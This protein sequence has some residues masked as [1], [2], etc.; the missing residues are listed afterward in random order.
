MTENLI[1][2]AIVILVGILAVF[3]FTIGIDKM[4]RIILGNYILSSICL[5]ASQS[6]NLA[7]QYMKTTPELTLMGFSYDKV[8]N[9]LSNG[10]MT[11]ILILYIILLV[12]VYRTSKIR[13]VLPGDEALKK[14]LQLIFVPL[15]VISMVL[16][17]QI[18]IL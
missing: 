7:V 2:Y 17:L 14:M 5:A 6:I 1:T 4:I 12:I 16:T 3:S 8:A 10:S 9:F 18:A 15:T 11:I 13:I